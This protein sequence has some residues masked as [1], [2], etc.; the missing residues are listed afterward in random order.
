MYRIKLGTAVAA[1]RVTLPP[2][3]KVAATGFNAI[4]PI[5]EKPKKPQAAVP[6]PVPVPVPA[7]AAGNTEMWDM[8]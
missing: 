6:V 1:G 5:W 8:L 7:P 3:P 4:T 2:K